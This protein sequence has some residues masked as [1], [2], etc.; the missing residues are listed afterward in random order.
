MVDRMVI[1]HG[2]AHIY[3]AYSAVMVSTGGRPQAAML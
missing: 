2:L 3:S 1:L